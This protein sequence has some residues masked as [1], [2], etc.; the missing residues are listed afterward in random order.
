MEQTISGFLFFVIAAVVILLVTGISFDMFVFYLKKI[1]CRH[2][3]N[4][5]CRVKSKPVDNFS[6]NAKFTELPTVE[7]LEALRKCSVGVTTIIL[8]CENCGNTKE[9]EIIGQEGW[10]DEFEYDRAEAWN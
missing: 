5:I 10:G 7:T 8:S 9:T 2:K 3:W 6:F 4:I 1:L